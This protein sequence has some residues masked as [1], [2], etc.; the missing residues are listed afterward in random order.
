MSIKLQGVVSDT[1]TCLRDAITEGLA[2]LRY[3][4]GKHEPIAAEEEL[5]GV[6]RIME[7]KRTSC[8]NLNTD[9]RTKGKNPRQPAVA[10]F[11]P[12]LQFRPYRLLRKPQEEKTSPGWYLPDSHD[13]GMA[14]EGDGESDF[15]KVAVRKRKGIGSCKFYSGKL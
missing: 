13:P 12:V 14:L 3:A 9:P 15:S 5:E 6:L 7:R 11:L 1:V 8:R 10:E 4:G 2:S